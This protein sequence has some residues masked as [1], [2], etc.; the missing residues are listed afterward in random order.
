M[1]IRRKCNTMLSSN[2]K[3]TAAAFLVI[4]NAF[5]VFGLTACSKTEPE[6]ETKA[7]VT[8]ETTEVPVKSADELFA[9]CDK[10]YFVPFKDPSRSYCTINDGLG[11][12]LWS[13]GMGGC[14]S[15]SAVKIDIACQNSRF[16]RCDRNCIIHAG[17]LIER[18][19]RNSLTCRKIPLVKL[20]G[21]S[22]IAVIREDFSGLC[23][24]GEPCGDLGDSGI[25]R[26]KC[27]DIR[28]CFEGCF[29]TCIFLS[30]ENDS[31]ALRRN[32]HRTEGV[33]VAAVLDK[34]PARDIRIVIG[35]VVELYPVVFSF[36]VAVSACVACA[37]LIYKD[38]RTVCR[39]IEL[40]GCSEYGSCRNH[41]C[42]TAKYF[43]FHIITLHNQSYPL[44]TCMIALQV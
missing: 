18:A 27:G 1:G 17:C 29:I 12:T 31:I 14:Y 13:Q 33:L 11:T 23:P 36:K 15:Y 35:R 6:S 40:H 3:R 32:A 24:A 5:S 8:H 10:E 20:I 22:R 2:F 16:L 28:A 9:G 26:D 43:C 25:Q 7:K 41:R 37:D 44:C 4:A 42:C 30:T 34:L 38:L 19:E 21:H 39:R